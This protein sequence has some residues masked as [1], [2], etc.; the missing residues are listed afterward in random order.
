MKYFIKRVMDV[1][2]SVLF[3]IIL[4]PV[5]F[6]IAIAIKLESGGE[7]SVFYK[8]KRIGKDGKSFTCFKFRSMKLSSDPNILSKD[9]N[10][11]RITNVG[12]LIRKTSLDEIPQLLNVLIGDMSFVGPRPA[13]PLQVE[14]FSKK[15]FNKLLVKPGITGWTQVNGRN[16]LDYEKRLE[17]DCWYARN[18][19]ILLDIQILLKTPFVI[20]K[21]EGIYDISR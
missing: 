2:L 19:N 17:M 1:F 16:S 7:G 9:Q 15:D 11:E 6:V 18:W 12:K 8:H 4:L 20:F 21:Q 10:D 13:L 14:Q 5:Y 3:I